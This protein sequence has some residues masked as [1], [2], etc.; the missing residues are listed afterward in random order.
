MKRECPEP[1]KRQFNIRS[2]KTKDYSQD[3]LQALVA[4]LREKDF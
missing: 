2:I 3:D 1:P 4:I